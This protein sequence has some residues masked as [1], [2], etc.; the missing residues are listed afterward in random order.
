M[1]LAKANDGSTAV[2]KG[3][4]MAVEKTEITGRCKKIH[5]RNFLLW[6]TKVPHTCTKG[7]RSQADNC[8]K[9]LLS[10]LVSPSACIKHVGT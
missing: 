3:E 10:S 8:N 5:T 7:S 4:P 6:F 9:S 2:W 1:F